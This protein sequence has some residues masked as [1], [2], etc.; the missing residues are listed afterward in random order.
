MTLAVFSSNLPG[1]F[2]V[3]RTVSATAALLAE[4]GITPISRQSAHPTSHQQEACPRPAINLGGKLK[5]AEDNISPFLNRISKV[6][7]T[8][9]DFQ[10]KISALK[11]RIFQKLGL[12]CLFPRISRSFEPLFKY[13]QCTL[14]LNDDG[15]ME[16]PTC[17]ASAC[18]NPSIED[19]IITRD[20][21]LPNV[22]SMIE[23]MVSTMDDCFEDMEKVVY[24]SRIQAKIVDDQPC[25]DEK[26]RNICQEAMSQGQILLEE[27]CESTG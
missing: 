4:P 2:S 1:T 21:G 12:S 11:S 19:R 17:N 16:T 13:V 15:F 8:I 26:Y 27:N 7:T 14:G 10:S 23:G 3:P 6:T 24:G 18:S 22:D 20:R 9:A 25:E 5:V